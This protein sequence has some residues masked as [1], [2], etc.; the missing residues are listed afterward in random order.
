MKTMPW[1]TGAALAFWGWQIGY[2]WLGLPAAVILEGGRLARWEWELTAADYRRIWDLS[3][4]LFATLA[5]YCY[6]S[7]ELL[8]AAHAFLRWL[9]LAFFPMI[10]AQWFGPLEKI[11]YRVFSWW[12]RYRQRSGSGGVTGAL[13]IAPLYFAGCLFAASAAGMTRPTIVWFY[14]G[15]TLLLAGALWQ[16]RPRR[17]SPWIWLAALAIAVLG[18]Y[19]GHRRLHD[20]QAVAENA[21]GNWI[22]TWGQKDADPGESRTAI[23]QIGKIKLSGRIAWRLETRPG[24]P[25]PELLRQASYNAY[26]KESWYS[27]VKSFVPAT[28][29]TNDGDLW[30]LSDKATTAQVSLAGYLPRGRGLL[31]LPAGAANVRHLVGGELEFNS[32]G[33]VRVKGGPTFVQF[34]TD[35]GPAGSLDGPPQ[36][37]DT[38]VPESE[39]HTLAGIVKE[40]GLERKT[41]REALDALQRFF[42]EGFRYTTFLAAND[43]RE[44]QITP[45]GDF[46]LHNRAGHCE[47][48]ATAT[49]L[50]LR[51]AGIPARYTTG[52]TVR[53]AR[54]HDKYLVRERHAH[55]WCRVYRKDQTAWEDFDTTPATWL[56]IED[57]RA[58]LTQPIADF[59]SGL[60][61]EFSK[62]RY[63]AANARQYVLA[64]LGL[65][66]GVLALQILLQRRRRKPA[67]PPAPTPDGPRAGDDSGYYRIER[68]LAD[69]GWGRRAAET[70]RQWQA[71]L[72]EST[73]GNRDAEGAARLGK[74][75]QRAPAIAPCS[76]DQPSPPLGG[77]ALD[78]LD[79]ILRL[80]YRHRFDPRGLGPEE[81][82]ALREQSR[83]W[84]ERAQSG[85]YKQVPP[86]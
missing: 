46:L 7:E 5:V 36:D 83:A 47:Y 24:R 28:L 16:I 73:R 35:Y 85:H 41:P 59:F 64:V 71:R 86:S 8:N 42:E 32:L 38:R 34:Q 25:A 11:D 57:A 80:H 1:L 18:G 19:E 67:A 82:R 68:F 70:P 9:P 76:Q 23:G 66:T 31:P 55:A 75:G 27:T 51:Q 3:A 12:L 77:A 40:L 2:W 65:A 69:L 13:N 15:F 74:D 20:L 79:G 33:T 6:T 22:A 53:E 58:S 61:Y 43:R 62:W 72:R 17:A 84:L 44:P 52:Y 4:A 56:A 63:G 37:E 60:W 10:L 50:L 26:R 14:A 39:T 29:A 49:V 30:L 45:L 78:A 81:K 48:F 54:G 21:L